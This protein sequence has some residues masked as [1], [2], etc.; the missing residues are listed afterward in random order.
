MNGMDVNWMLWDVI[1]ALACG[2]VSGV[3][4]GLFVA[5]WWKRREEHKDIERK[6]ED[7]VLELMFTGERQLS[8]DNNLN[9]SDL[10]LW[11]E[12]VMEPAQDEMVKL[13]KKD[14]RWLPSR[15]GNIFEVEF[16]RR[17][18]ARSEL[19]GKEQR[20][21]YSHWGGLEG[22]FSIYSS[23]NSRSYNNYMEKLKRIEKRMSWYAD[24]LKG[25]L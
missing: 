3:I 19:F 20:R 2:V 17:L 14:A 9:T 15:W 16:E 23:R 24:K 8:R 6:V 13:A 22:E 12:K 11:R 5:W 1:V 10:W 4:S 21:T 18:R 7:R 25:Y